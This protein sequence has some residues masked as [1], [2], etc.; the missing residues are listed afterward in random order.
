MPTKTTTLRRAVA[1][2]FAFAILLSLSGVSQGYGFKNEGLK[3]T[4]APVRVPEP[5]NL[6]LLGSGLV[7]VGR[8]IKRRSS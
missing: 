1:T 6:L 3:R 4:F 5:M 8:T 2:L 7:L